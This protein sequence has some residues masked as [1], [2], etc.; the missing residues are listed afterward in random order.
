MPSTELL[1]LGFVQCVLMVMSG[2]LMAQAQEKVVL[3][4]ASVIGGGASVIK[5][6]TTMTP[7]LSVDSLAF[8]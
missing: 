5:S 6:G 8:Q 3:K 1:N 4:S 7:M 2:S